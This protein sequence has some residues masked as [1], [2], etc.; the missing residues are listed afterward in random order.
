MK[1]VPY[2]QLSGHSLF[3]NVEEFGVGDEKNH[4][5]VAAWNK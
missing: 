3:F 1:P 2:D 4:N 5:T